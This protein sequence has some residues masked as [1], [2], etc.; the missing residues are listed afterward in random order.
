MVMMWWQ[1]DIRITATNIKKNQIAK[2]KPWQRKLMDPIE[3]CI[4]TART[5]A[6]TLAFS[7]VEG[8][9]FISSRW[10]CELSNLA[11]AFPT[12]SSS[13]K[14]RVSSAAQSRMLSMSASYQMRM[15][16]ALKIPTCNKKWSKT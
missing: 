16:E 5:T 11:A 6:M 13:E 4:N 1:E 2:L 3:P 15:A 12:K 14:M 8:L 9:A 10:F 7:N